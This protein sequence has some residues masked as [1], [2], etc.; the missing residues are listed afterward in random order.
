M[1]VLST[2][3]RT[4]RSRKNSSVIKKQRAVAYHEAGHAVALWSQGLRFSE[5]SII[6]DE[7]TDTLGHVRLHFP[8]WFRPDY[9][10]STRSR[11]YAE[12]QIIADFAGKIAE[13]RFVRRNVREGIWK[14]YKDAFNMACYFCSTP[15]TANTFLHFL[16]SMA[17]DLIASRWWAV[18]AVANALVAERHL[19]HKDVVSI[20]DR[21]MQS[22]AHVSSA[23]HRR[24]RTRLSILNSPIRDGMNG[25]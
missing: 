11:L 10:A 3:V 4:A 22:K 23:P 5:A 19:R 13:S 12:K 16:F 24:S 20:I 14:D 9:D 1:S 6:A 18:V 7:L 21:A 17:R 8:K 25:R 2:R 15:K